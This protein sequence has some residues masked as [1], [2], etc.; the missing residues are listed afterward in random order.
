[1]WRK[2]N[3]NPCGRGV[4]DCAVRAVAVALGIDWE[5]AYAM[6]VSAG[7]SMCDMPS[8]NSVWGAVLRSNGFYKKEVEPYIT[9]GE[10]VSA[11]PIGTFVL[12]SGEH[13]A[14]AIDGSLID[15]WDSRNEILSYYWYRKE[16]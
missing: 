11:H 9:F 4:G 3:P 13:T 6:I 8:S 2:Y 15:A 1:M 5:T 10:F 12:G 7:F 16:E 14:T